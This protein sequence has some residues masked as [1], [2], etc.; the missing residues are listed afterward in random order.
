MKEGNVAEWLIEELADYD[1]ANAFLD[2]TL[3]GFKEDKDTK[4]FEYSLHLL[5]QAQKERPSELLDKVNSFR[6]RI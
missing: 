3:K 5:Y 1:V 6:N 4:S 2:D